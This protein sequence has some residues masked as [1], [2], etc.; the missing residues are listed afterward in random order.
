MLIILNCSCSNML[1]VAVV[2]SIMVLVNSLTYFYTLMLS[3]STLSL[4]S[5]NLSMTLAVVS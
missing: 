5:T 4:I 1:P 3:I 2:M